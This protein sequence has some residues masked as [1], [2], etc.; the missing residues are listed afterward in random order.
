M[1]WLQPAIDRLQSER[2]LVRI[3]VAAT[4]GSTPRDA[5]AWM[6]VSDAEIVG[7][8]GGGRLEWEALAVA[9][10]QLSGEQGAAVL[11][12]EWILGPDL[13]QCCGGRVSL[14]CERL[15]GSALPALRS[16]QLV[17]R[18]AG[19]VRLL[20]RLESDRVVREVLPVSA[21]GLTEVPAARLA[22]SGTVRLEE[23]FQASEP[24]LL[25]FGAG[26][27]GQAI[28]R[29]LREA[30]AFDLR[31]ID[32]R[33]DI[34][35]TRPGTPPHEWL[36]DPLLAAREAKD[37]ALVLVM[38]HDHE[39]DY[40]LCRAVLAANR[41]SYLGLIAS[42][43][44]AARFRSRLAREGLEAQTRRLLTAPIGLP[45]IRG[46]APGVVAVSVVAQLLMLASTSAV[47]RRP[48]P[49]ETACSGGDCAS[50]APPARRAP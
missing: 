37:G 6:L 25:L 12:R 32:S 48:A 47:G 24:S 5:G 34:A 10:A 8:I 13:R 16:A 36:P 41:A 18:N 31:L 17:L 45:G 1:N 21:A 40:A 33:R 19:G 35:I 39:L 38:T 20:T 14:W 26:H 44:K 46:K 50:C 27:V 9:R 28:A 23:C 15:D 49:V 22:P 29:L 4:R 3:S 11:I 7:T 30:P 43:S 2:P 42:D